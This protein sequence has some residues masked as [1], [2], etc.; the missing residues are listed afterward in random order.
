MEINLRVIHSSMSRSSLF[1][2]I[3]SNKRSSARISS[4]AL[5]VSSVRVL[6][7]SV[8]RVASSSSG[9]LQRNE[10][11]KCQTSLTFETFPTAENEGNF[12]YDG[13]ASTLSSDGMLWS[14]SFWFAAIIMIREVLSIVVYFADT[15]EM[16]ILMERVVHRRFLFSL[17]AS[18]IPLSRETQVEIDVLTA[19][20]LA[21]NN[22]SESTFDHDW[23]VAA[24]GTLLKTNHNIKHTLHTTVSL[25]VHVFILCGFGCSDRDIRW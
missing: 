13:L 16:S 12:T 11:K 24:C 6:S 23:C 18:S 10:R 1:I 21:D 14:S 25:F 7:F 20:G 19:L 17:V 15:L 9:L 3:S 4:F 8:V 2:S 22:K 5:E